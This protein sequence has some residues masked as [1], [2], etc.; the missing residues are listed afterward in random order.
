[1]TGLVLQIDDKSTVKF[2][3]DSSGLGGRELNYVSH[4]P[5]LQQYNLVI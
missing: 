2:V 5:C 3:I 4:S 1:M